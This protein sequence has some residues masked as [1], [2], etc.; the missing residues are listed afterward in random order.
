MLSLIIGFSFTNVRANEHNRRQLPCAS[1]CGN[2][3][4]AATS[5]TDLNCLCPTVLLSASPCGSCLVTANATYATALQSLVADCTSPEICVSQ[6]SGI[7]SAATACSTNLTCICPVLS[8]SGS[9]CIACLTSAT[10]NQTDALFVSSYLATDCHGVTSASSSKIPLTS[11]MSGTTASVSATG[12][13]SSQPTA[14]QT[15][16]SKSGAW[17]GRIGTEMYIELVMV[18]AIMA[19]LFGAFV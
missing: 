8:A 17:S 3:L 13:T 15:M 2:I 6:C 1:Q 4:S 5:C 18:G 10:P 19:G 7:I 14:S 11:P 9:S 16:Q 12:T